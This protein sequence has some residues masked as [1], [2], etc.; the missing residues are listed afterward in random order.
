MDKDEGRIKFD[1]RILHKKVA[2]GT[3]KSIPDEA[4]TIDFQMMDI[5]MEISDEVFL[6]FRLRIVSQ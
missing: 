5:S 6:F 4:M 1:A 3:P 2:R